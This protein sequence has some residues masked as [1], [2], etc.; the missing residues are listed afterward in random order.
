MTVIGV[1]TAGAEVAW[2]VSVTGDL[3]IPSGLNVIPSC[4]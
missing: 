3:V 2:T 4:R 1:I